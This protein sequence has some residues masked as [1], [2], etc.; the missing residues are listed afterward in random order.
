[1]YAKILEIERMRAE[2][3]QGE[4]KKAA[5][6]WVAHGK[7]AGVWQTHTHT[8]NQRPLKAAKGCKDAAAARE[9]RQRE[10]GVIQIMDVMQKG[11]P[12]FYSLR[13]RL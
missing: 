3:R 6:V 12:V 10:R 2:G 9:R 11:W 7:T 5:H 1:M 4:V 8:R 13:R